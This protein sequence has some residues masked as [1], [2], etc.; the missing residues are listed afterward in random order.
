MGIAVLVT[1]SLS[2]LAQTMPVANTNTDRP[3]IGLVLSG[4]GA[5]GAAHIGVL[6]VL[7][8]PR[9]PIDAIAGASMGALVGG[10]YASGMSVV[11]M[12]QR[13]LAIRTTDIVN[14]DPPRPEQT[15]RRK[16]DTQSNFLGPEFGLRGG[17]LNLP[18]GAVSGIG[19][20]AMLRDF[21][22]SRNV[23]HFD[24]LQIPFRAVATDIE[25]G[26]VQVLD[27][28]DLA[29]ALR[30]SISIP[31]LFAPA[32]LGGRLLVDGGLTRNL[33]VDVARQMGVDVVIAVNLGTPLLRRD[34]IGSI[35]GV[36][37]QMINIL[38]EQNV[39]ASL[40][41]LRPHDVLISPALGEFS[42]IDFDHMVDAVAQGEAAARAMSLALEKLALAPSAYAA[43]RSRSRST[44]QASPANIDEIRFGALQHV[45]PEVLRSMLETQVGRPLDPA[46]LD[47]D[48]LRLYGRGDFDH[49]GYSLREVDGHRVLLIDAKERSV[50]PDY[51]RFGIGLSNDF[52]GNAY[53]QTRTSLRRTWVNALG[54]EWRSDLQLG[55]INQLTTE[56][57]QPLNVHQSVFVAPYVDVEQKPYEIFQGQDRTARFIRQ[58]G[59]LGFDVGTQSSGLGE[60]RLGVFAGRRS[61][62]LDTGPAALSNI[63]D[64]IST[65]GVRLGWRKDQLDHGL[66][67][68]HGYALSVDTTA[69]LPELGA[70]DR[71]TRWDANYVAAFSSGDHTV[72]L[73]LRSGGAIGGSKLPVYDLFQFGGLMQ[74]SGFRTGQLLGRSLAFG[75]VVY[76]RR[77]VSSPLLKGMFGGVSL[78]AG[79][80]GGP[81]L[82]TNATGLL[83]AGSVFLATDTPIGPVYLALG[84][85][86]GGNRSLYLYLGTP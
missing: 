22:G 15:E 49:V 29:S 75:R 63:E 77:I 85:A 55:R 13:I 46:V 45:N 44:V 18:I 56:F 64:V 65:G 43:Y 31:G 62:K 28:G 5:R 47:D 53:F 26:R 83:T 17:E 19:L 72:Q 86:S 52:S 3:R 20:E 12:E 40:A 82:P 70:R 23:V 48:L 37:T 61:F 35:V 79:R 81:L 2:G 80:V 7:E 59:S 30:A 71:Y 51:L 1:H 84:I 6:R 78:E 24:S 16:R 36:T 8:E 41:S 38:T 74:L 14:D 57:Y 21:V 34:Q 39:R 10:A 73:G 33:P 9:V 32:A 11:E 58:S 67:P 69:S 25:T 60:M 66:F 42:A 76:V 4:G 54:A 68:R 27:S 50:G